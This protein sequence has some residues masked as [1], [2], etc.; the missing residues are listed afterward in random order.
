MH[1][2]DVLS[3]AFAAA[4]NAARPESVLPRFLPEPPA[5]R[6]VVVGAGKAAARMALAVDAAWPADLTGVVITPYGHAGERL[7]QRIRVLEAAHPVPDAAGEE[8]TREVL[9]AVSNL[10]PNDLVLCLLSGG[11]SALLTAPRGVT[12]ARKAELTRA[13]LACG[14]SIHEINAVRKHLSR[15][16]GGGLANAAKPARVVS[17]IVSDVVGDDLSTIAS[18]PTAPDPTSFTEAFM[19]LMRHD[20]AVPDVRRFLSDG[21]AGRHAE[22]PK[23]GD[24]LFGR[25]ENHLVVTN[26]LALDAASVHLTRL[27][28]TSR[29]VS[30]R[31]EGP[32]RSAA[33]AH[34]A[35]ARDLVSGRALLSGGETTTIV[36]EGAGRGGRNLEFLLALAVELGEDHGL[37]ALAAD[38]D[39]ID[40]TSFAAGGFLT[41]DT[42]RRARDLGL[43]ARAF[44]G[45]SDAHGFFE[46]LG[47]LVVTGPTGTNVNDIRLV[48]RA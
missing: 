35:L 7:P 39:G 33:R 21:A 41:P 48:V 47:D 6:T 18:G 37:Y 44:L 30:D 16:K 28:F 29:I 20:V 9:E 17:L 26:R 22:T 4:V 5:G 3:S 19:V 10:T 8:A 45:A 40:G 11:G 15:V 38:S 46:A 14:A 27:G 43:D 32:A 1:P 42:L 24:E 23:P 31:I 34:A 12:L 2:R 36:R 13:L 25:V